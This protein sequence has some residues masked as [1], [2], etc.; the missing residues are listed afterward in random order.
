MK[1]KLIVISTFVLFGASILLPVLWPMSDL[2]WRRPVLPRIDAI[3]F[4]ID[5]AESPVAGVVVKPKTTAELEK[6]FQGADENHVPRVF[7]DQLP[8]DFKKKGN[9]KLFAQVISALILREN[10]RI[11]LERAI[12]SLM[13]FKSP[14]GQKWTQKEQD[15]F[16]HLV[17]R[18]DSLAKKEVTAQ[19]ADLST[20]VQP[21]PPLMGVLQ[22][23]E[24]TDWGKKHF[25]SPFEQMG[26]LNKK[27]YARV[28]FKSLIQATESYVTEMNGMPPLSTWRSS[29]SKALADGGDDVG[30]QVIRWLGNYKQED[31][32]YAEKLLR[33]S[34][35]L[36]YEIPD[37]L[38]FIKISK[39]PSREVKI[40]SHTFQMEFAKEFDDRMRGLMFRPDIPSDTGMVFI[41]DKLQPMG[42][43][44][45]N[46]FVSL[47]IVFFGKDKKVTGI[48]EKL[49]PLDETPRRS[50]EPTLGMIEL[51]AGTVKQYK[52][53]VGDKIVF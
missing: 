18:Y 12:L 30:F 11:T 6:W 44:M 21:I 4:L 7:V 52:I 10:E 38:A 25:E 42:V 39:L 51:P 47:D 49:A 29:R 46:T 20:K 1:R 9:Q 15:F 43:W 24:A 32:E 53:K 22:A 14:D 33:R 8:K 16:Q 3:K 17:K 48:F 2:A 50:V 27:T 26:W 13:R 31:P 19:I 40:G 37:R 5:K 35:E 36:D 28:P 41:N 34:D 23:A 45:K